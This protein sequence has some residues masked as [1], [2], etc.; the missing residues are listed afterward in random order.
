MAKKP[1]LADIATRRQVHL[2]RLKTSISNE[3][4]EILKA[5]GP[6]V[7]K[8]L[9]GLGVE[10]LSE[11]SKKELDALLLK[12]R[13]RNDEIINKALKSATK[14]FEELAGDE[15]D[16]ERKALA[17]AT[18]A[19]IKIN[20]V[21]AAET[22]A[23]ALENPVAATGEMLSDFFAKFTEKQSEQVSS[24]IAKGYA[25]GV[26]T[27]DIVRAIKG[28]K[29][30]N[31]SDGIIAAARHNITAIVRTAVQHVASSARFATW[32]AN[33]DIVKRY[34]FV[35]TLDGRTSQICRSTD[36]ETYELGKGPR[37][38]LHINCRSTTVAVIE[39]FAFLDEGAT[40]ASADGYQDAKETYYSWLEKQPASFQ[41]SAIGPTRGKLFRNGG[42]SADK[43]ARLNLGSNFQPLTLAE[44]RKL[45]PL[46]F[47]TA[48]L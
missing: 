30:L 28:T 41:D 20:G 31:Y 37:P 17:G 11:L 27:P 42:L 43:F 22:Y 45:E 9:I 25:N 10:R 15:S 4:V 34:R 29:K 6:S 21:T 18:K 36:G 8:E 5:I 44:M 24:I 12:L 1:S 3:S 33:S 35:A 32:E 7:E 14:N 26:N 16:F 13:A 2:E 23:Y 47:E 39:E 38:P 46:A 19:T 40:R 48:G